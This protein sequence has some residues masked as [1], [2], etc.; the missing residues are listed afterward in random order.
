M[1]A[2]SIAALIKSRRFHFDNEGDLQQG[3]SE[4]L[5]GAGIE[6]KRE[7]DIGKGRI[8]F[9]V[10]S[11]GIEVKVGGSLK[12]ATRQLY[13]YAECDRVSELILVSSRLFHINL[14]AEMN[15]KPLQ[16]ISLIGSIF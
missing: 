9:L 2:E 6:F 7:E 4:V 5:T 15:G 12:A 10:G 1:D 16:A 11:I 14:P 13:R 3:I 8:D